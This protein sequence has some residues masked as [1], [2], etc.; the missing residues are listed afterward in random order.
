MAST[1]TA[2]APRTQS[3]RRPYRRAWKTF[4]CDNK[5][6]QALMPSERGVDDGA[7]T[8][9][10]LVCYKLYSIPIN[11]TFIMNLYYGS[12]IEAGIVA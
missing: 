1:L 2:V 6:Q 4:S 8:S 9:M 5:S 3:V 11:S 10:H 12:K 7:H